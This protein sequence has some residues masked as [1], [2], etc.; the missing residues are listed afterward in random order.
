MITI[1]NVKHLKGNTQEG[2]TATVKCG[3]KSVHV[4]FN[5]LTRQLIIHKWYKLTNA[6]CEAVEAF[7][8]QYF[9]SMA[10]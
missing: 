8:S 5:C 6:E 7:T 10:A 9:S 3:E 4:V 2:Y 1:S